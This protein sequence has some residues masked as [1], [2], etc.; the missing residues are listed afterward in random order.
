M[1]KFIVPALFAFLFVAASCMNMSGGSE[2]GGS[3]RVALP[4]GRYVYSKEKADKFVVRVIGETETKEKEAMLGGVIEFTELEPGEYTVEAEARDSKNNDELI[5]SGSKDIKVEADKTT[6]CSFSLIISNCFVAEDG[7]LVINKTKF[8]KTAL[9]TVIDT[10][11]TITGSGS[12]G[13][14]IDGRTVTLS[15]YSIGKY[16]VTQELFEAVMGKNPSN[17]KDSPA[18]GETQELRPVESISWYHAIVFCNRL[19]ILMGLEECYTA[20]DGNGQKIDCKNVAY[21][22]IKPNSTSD[23]NTWQKVDFD[24]SKNGYRLPTVAEWEFAARGGKQGGSDWNY[25]YAGSNDINKVAWYTANSSNVSHEV[26]LKKSNSLG[27]YD[28]SGNCWEFCSDRSSSIPS[29][30]VTDPCAEDANGGCVRKSGSFKDDDTWASVSK[31]Y[32][33]SVT[34]IKTYAYQNNGIRLARTIK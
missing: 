3:I 19:S 12:E 23:K 8:E 25:T 21:S 29:G 2:K 24:L 34:D 32:T 7:S 28:M 13:V 27:L 16:E 10:A 20:Y 15:P 14:F 17:F 11:T 6:E 18:D 33:N 5:A 26:G 30:E 1:K 31:S 9:A 4:G 22:D